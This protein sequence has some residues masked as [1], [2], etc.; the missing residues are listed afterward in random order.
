MESRGKVIYDPSSWCALAASSSSSTVCLFRLSIDE[1]PEFLLYMFRRRRN[2]QEFR[3]TQ[4][5]NPSL[6]VSIEKA[7]K[8]LD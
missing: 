6:F 8:Y 3:R 2:Q 4:V 7:L 1:K 5:E